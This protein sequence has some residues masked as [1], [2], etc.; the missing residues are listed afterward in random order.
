MMNKF[1]V[2]RLEKLAFEASFTD[3]ISNILLCRSHRPEQK[4][5][6]LASIPSLITNNP[7]LKSENIITLVRTYLN[8]Y[9]T[10]TMNDKIR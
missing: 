5:L 7:V 3:L 10:G 6:P 4:Q 8:H 2:P 9:L 1:G